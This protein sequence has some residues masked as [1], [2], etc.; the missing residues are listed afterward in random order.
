MPAQTATRVTGL[1]TIP[2]YSCKFARAGRK[3]NLMSVDRAAVWADQDDVAET[4]AV[5]VTL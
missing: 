5:E 1:L 2:K 4:G 3:D